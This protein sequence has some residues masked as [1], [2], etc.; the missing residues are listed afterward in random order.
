MIKRLGNRQDRTVF[1]GMLIRSLIQKSKKE[2][3]I[4]W[5]AEALGGTK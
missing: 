3:E 1:T 4:K 2:M 5:F